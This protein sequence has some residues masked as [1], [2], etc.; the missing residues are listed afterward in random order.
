MKRA[1][2][3]AS[4]VGFMFAAAALLAAGIPAHA[5]D[6]HAPDWQIA[7]TVHYGPGGNASGY[8]AIVALRKDDAWAFGGT[9]PGGASSPTAEHWNGTRWQ[10][11]SL[12]PG[13]S[14]FIV[15]ADAS[16]AG[17]IWAV[18]DGY[19]LRWNGTQW[20]VAKTWAPF[21]QLTSV[22]AINT[23]D[24]WVFGSSPFSGEVSLGAWHFNGRA[25]TRARGMANSI[26]RASAVA[27]RDIWGIT[28][29]PRG[30][31]VAHY[32]GHA[33]ARVRS[34][35]SALASTQLD[36]VLAVSRTSVWVS[37]ISPASGQ[38]GHLVLAHWDGSRWKRFVAPWAVQQP[39]RFA[40]DGAGGIWIPVVTGG[41]NPA[42]WILH[43]SRTGQWTRTRIA[44]GPAA[45]VGVG[46]LALIPGT[47][48]LWGSGG[49]LT[50]AGGD[51]TIWAHLAVPTG[52]VGHHAEAAG[53]RTYVTK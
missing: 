1:R 53:E 38:A 52:A 21:R 28:T 33:W 17:N 15:A 16:S 51:A 9:N 12:P 37:G 6:A 18:G 44:A 10:S 25:W 22:A 50:I 7:A 48:S 14:G 40:S 24:V 27:S 34:A 43:M 20:S 3:A 42:T 2:R 35:A 46:D 47:T 11:S 19:A 41:G 5:A 23:G 13:L 30:G 32:N 49:L 29:G 45:G 26:Y 36:N 8:S 4:V 39:E 31:S